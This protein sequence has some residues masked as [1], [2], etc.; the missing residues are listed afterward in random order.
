MTSET[1]ISLAAAALF[2]VGC[3]EEVKNTGRISKDRAGVDP[4]G[5]SAVP[6]DPKKEQN[7]TPNPSANRISSASG[8][9]VTIS[10]GGAATQGVVKLSWVEPGPVEGSLELAGSTY[11]VH[12]YKNQDALNCWLAHLDDDP[13]RTRRGMLLG[14]VAGNTIKGTFVIA[15]NGGAA[16]INGTWTAQL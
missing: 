16:P 8:S 6:T 10:D 1:I 9:A 4:K 11:Q 13:D 14:T 15:G 2:F 7:P 12:G 3:G 5:T